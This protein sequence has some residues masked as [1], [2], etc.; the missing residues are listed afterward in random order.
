M[1]EVADW[2]VMVESGRVVEEGLFGELASKR[3]RF[4]ELNWTG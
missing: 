1:M 3:G 4:A 2:I